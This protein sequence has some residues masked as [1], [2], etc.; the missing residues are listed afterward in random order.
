MHTVVLLFPIDTVQTVA[1]EAR[2][3]YGGA[4]TLVLRSKEDYV[5]RGMNK[6][7]IAGFDPATSHTRFI[8][9]TNGADDR[10]EP[11]IQKLEDSGARY[12]KVKYRRKEGFVPES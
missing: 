11:V 9:V 10:L 5:P 6:Q 12:E 3:N 4:S 7:D 8:V 1:K 2:H